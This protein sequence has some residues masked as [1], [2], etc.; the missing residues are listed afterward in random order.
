MLQEMAGKVGL[1]LVPSTHQSGNT[2][3]HGR[4]TKQGASRARWL[5]V[6]AAQHLDRHPG[7]LGHFFRR[8]ARKKNRNVAVVATARKL[9]V[10]AYHMLRAGEPYRWAQ[11]LP[12]ATGARRRGGSP[13][14]KPRPT[15]YGSG[16]RTRA[17]PSLAGVCKAEGL[18]APRTL[19]DLP[20]GEI[21][22]IKLTHSL[23]HARAIQN[24]TTRPRATATHLEEKTQPTKGPSQIIDSQRHAQGTRHFQR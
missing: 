18:P 6:Q 3:Y 12:T 17:V 2:C 16:E 19:D 7:P 5:L 8:L 10:I 23:T 20:A 4:I 1:G 11:P 22:V 9:A 15:S 14:G 24:P 13:K 21:R